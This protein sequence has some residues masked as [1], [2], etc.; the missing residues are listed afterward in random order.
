MTPPVEAVPET[1]INKLFK[2]SNKGDSGCE[3]LQPH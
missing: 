3:G 2:A 1:A